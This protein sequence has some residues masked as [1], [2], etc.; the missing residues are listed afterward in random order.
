ML[1]LR[2]RAA[3]GKRQLHAIHLQVRRKSLPSA[4][5]RPPNVLTRLGP[6]VVATPKDPWAGAFPLAWEDPFFPD[7]SDVQGGRRNLS[8]AGIAQWNYRARQSRLLHRPGLS[9][10][11]ISPWTD[12]R[13]D[14]VGVG[15]RRLRVKATGEAIR[16]GRVQARFQTSNGRVVGGWRQIEGL[17]ESGSGGGGVQGD[18]KASKASERWSAK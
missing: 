5:V 9:H 16:F 10:A 2:G 4:P 12:G 14:G 13:I 3:R 1:P 6:R 15:R 7:L 11:L 18:S 17:C 8:E